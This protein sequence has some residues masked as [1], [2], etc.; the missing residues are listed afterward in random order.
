MTKI[1]KRLSSVSIAALAFNA[2]SQT[3]LNDLSLASESIMQDS[4]WTF[5]LMAGIE[6]EPTYAG[7]KNYES[8]PNA[9]IRASYRSKNGNLYQF[10]LGEAK[11]TFPL[12]ENWFAQVIFEYEEGRDADE[13]PILKGLTP[14]PSTIEGELI[15]AYRRNN[16]YLYA[17]LQPDVL[18]RG[19]GLVYFIGGGMDFATED[20][21]WSLDT[22]FDIAWGN[23]EYMMTEFGISSKDAAATGYQAYTPG[24]GSK[25]T[26][27][28]LTVQR[29]LTEHWSLIGGASVECYF[30]KAK[31]SPLIKT[32]GDSTSTEFG[33]G[34]IYHF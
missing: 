1:L 26:T 33:L 17:H 16:K 3:D 29:R 19:K 34:V 5:E 11:A 6:H 27:L 22:R 7:S 20:G 21:K 14:V 2:Y 32:Y 9:N 15:L 18:G 12:S 8:E 25:S 10:G 4:Q 24:A 30:S 13:E 23:S 31:E 28:D